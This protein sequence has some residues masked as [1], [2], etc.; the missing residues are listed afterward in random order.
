[1][2]LLAPASLT[3]QF[4]SPSYAAGFTFTNSQVTQHAFTVVKD[5]GG[6]WVGDGG[7]A[8]GNRLF[9]YNTAGAFQTAYAPG[10]DFRSVFGDGSGAIYARQFNDD[11]IYRMTSPGSFS[12]WLTLAGIPDAQSNV[13]FDAGN[14]R[15]IA[16]SGGSVQSYDAVTGSLVGT[17][18][19]IG[20]GGSENS[21]PQNRGI[22]SALGKWLTYNNG[23]LSMWDPTTGTRLGTTSLTGAGTG[24]DAEFSL[25]FTGGSAWVADGSGGNNQWR[26]YD[27]G[28]GGVSPVPEP[29]SIA[30]VG[31]G[32]AGMGVVGRRRRRS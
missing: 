13:V 30:L 27:V 6:F 9:R 10:L 7:G 18:S 19:L 17:T 25:S 1:M 14:T 32:L 22:V 4:A 24:F 3:A 8:W 12:N 21:Y 28:L 15:L 29:S 16:M 20:F 11:A 5:A 26:E 2:A 31:L 23:T